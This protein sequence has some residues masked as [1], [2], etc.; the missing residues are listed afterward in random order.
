MKR[1]ES[2][3]VYTMAGVIAAAFIAATAY[4]G[5]NPAEIIPQ[6]GEGWKFFTED[7][8]PPQVSFSEAVMECI[9]VTIS[10]AISSAFVAAILAV[11]AAVFGSEKTSPSRYVAGLI[12]GAATFLR[13]IPTLVWAFILFSSLGVGTSVGFIALVITS[14]AFMTRTF[15]EVIDEIPQD[16]LECMEAVGANFWQRMFQCV[17]PCCIAGFISWFLYCLEVNI[18][19][20]TIVGMVG[21]GGSGMVLLSYLKAFKYPQAAGIILMIAAIVIFVDI[22]TGCLRKR[23]MNP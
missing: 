13:N 15:I 11:V 4:T 3:A 18:R 19:A 5:F 23:V 12:R 1:N 7:F 6:L 14:F 20:S 2:H 16:T 21:G 22:M 17:I 8:L 9:A 10:L